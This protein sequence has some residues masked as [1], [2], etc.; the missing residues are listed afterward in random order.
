[1]ESPYPHLF[2]EG[3]IKSLVMKNRLVL[4][5]LCDNMS[6]RAGGV[7]DQKVEYFRRRAEGGV[8]WIN[9]GYAYVSRRGRGCTYF[10]VGVYG[11]ELIPG[12][13]RLTDTVHEHD[14]RMGC[15]IAHAGRQTTHHYIDGQTP[16]APSALAEG[17]LGEVPEEMGVER[18]AELQDEFAQAARRAREAG[19][20]LVELHGA[21]GYLFQ[22]FMSPLSN[23]RTDEYGGSFEN[24]FRFLGETVRAVRKEV[25]DDFPVGYRISGSEFSEG[26][27]TIEDTV[28]TVQALEREGIDYVH[29]SGGSYESFHMMIAPMGI[30]PGQL[31]PLAAEV[32]KNVGIPVV[33]VGRYNTPELAERVLSDG[34]ADFIA[35]GRELL[36][37][38][39]FPR[40][41]RAGRARDIRPCIACEQGCIDRWVAALDITC[42]GNP[43][44]GR[45]LLPGW[46]TPVRADEAGSVL[47]LGGGPA[48]LEA[49]RVAALRGHRVTL[50]EREQ[51]LGG[52]MALAAR[53]PKGEEWQRLVDW[54]AGQAA[55][56][57]VDILTGRTA[58]AAGVIA[59]GADAVVVATGARPLVPRH[60]PGWDLP[61]VTDPI[62]ALRD[63]SGVG[64]RVVIYGGD[65]IGAQTALYLAAA[66]REVTLVAQGRSDLFADGIDEFAND[67][68]GTIV[69][70]LILDRLRESVELR[71]KQGLKRIV[72][73]GAVVDTAGAFP[74]HTSALRFGPV[75]EE[76]LPADTVVI[77]VPR[78]PVDALYDELAGT[79]AEL[80]LVG[81]A[82]EPRTVE[83]AIR[84]GS[85]AARSIGGPPVAPVSEPQPALAG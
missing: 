71:P 33:S 69:R 42:I 76:I 5:S 77:G 37:D 28:E 73:G 34:H 25:G 19:F 14:V 46:R 21:H 8:G 30:G 23:R 35:T 7:T 39:D 32:K 78:R 75:D 52:Q 48:G 65:T 61:H 81:D 67:M 59:E 74:P 57:G 82:A 1:M 40:K 38:P 20:D 80:H 44:T 84:E 79:V 62:S 18:I 51:T 26:G 3:Q 66:G 9:L 58:T 45:E 2:S 72:E 49:A 31:E 4:P 85:A 83:E 50:W 68:V 63:S 11:D 12:L 16:E 41:A 27:L 6:D 17:V 22:T 36:A 54:L 64:A 29:I 47:V 15:Q 24:R 60:I 55:E 13:R 56:Q 43:E 53:A 70:P 10:Q